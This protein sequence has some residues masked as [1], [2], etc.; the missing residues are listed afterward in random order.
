MDPAQ[1][2]D[3]QDSPQTINQNNNTAVNGQTPPPINPTPNPVVNDLNKTPPANPE[4]NP[5]SPLNPPNNSAENPEPTPIASDISAPVIPSIPISN[6]DPAN[7]PV[8]AI[9]NTN[10]PPSNPVGQDTLNTESSPYIPNIPSS[11]PS[12]AEIPSYQA[13]EVSSVTPNYT[14]GFPSNDANNLPTH[15][16]TSTRLPEHTLTV[17]VINTQAPSISE[18]FASLPQKRKFPIMA[19]TVILII[20]TGASIGSVYFFKNAIVEQFPFLASYLPAGFLQTPTVM[21]TPILPPPLVQA[22]TAQPSPSPTPDMNPFASPTIAL[23]NPF[24][25]PT[26]ILSN[27]FGTYENP[28]TDATESAAAASAP[29]QNPFEEMK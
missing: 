14:P 18:T 21:P 27:P 26:A 4:V 25:S 6:I 5:N 17:P 3:N 12:S 28:F 24:A 13:T 10:Q 7:N 1:K 2:P 20:V 15:E 11:A 9:N 22:P 19:I 23:D 8:P 16:D 29:Y